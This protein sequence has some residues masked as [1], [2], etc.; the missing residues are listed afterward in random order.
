MMSVYS[1]LHARNLRERKVWAILAFALVI[2]TIPVF[3]AVMGAL[4]TTNADNGDLTGTNSI[5][6]MVSEIWGYGNSTTGWKEATLTLAAP[7]YSV[8][9]TFPAGFK[10]SYA[11]IA[12]GNSSYNV[13][14]ILEHSYLY[15]Y[16]KITTTTGTKLNDAYSYIATFHNSSAVTARSDKSVVAPS[17]NTTL[18]SSQTNNLGQEVAY[19][20]LNLFASNYN[21]VPTYALN[22]SVTNTSSTYQASFTFE[23]YLQQ[24]YTYNLFFDAA[25]I[26]SIVAL[27][28]LALLWNVLP[29]HQGGMF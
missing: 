12:T 25:A 23:N 28:D 7:S 17:V 26:M 24:P 21:A 1:H 2:L 10:V 27:V 15:S 22:L 6:S 13:L 20:I 18:Y 8:T 14:H 5:T 29:R 16:S 4:A 11:I 9:A 3:A 19:P